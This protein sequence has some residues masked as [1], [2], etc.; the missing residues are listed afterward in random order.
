M[1]DQDRDGVAA[2]IIYPT[3]GMMLCNHTDVDYKRACFE[4]Y[5]RWI[6]EYCSAHPDRLLGSGPDRDAHA[7]GGHR[8]PRTTI[9]ALGLRGVMMPGRARRRGLRLDRS[10]TTFWEAAIE[11]GLPLSFHIL[12]SGAE[13]D[14]R[15][16]DGRLPVASSAAARTSWRCSCSA[17]CSSATRTCA[18]VCVEADAGWVPHFMY[19]MDHAYKRH[20]YWLPPGQELSKLP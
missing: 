2:E 10:T 7:R 6:A 4:A 18:I 20:R 17:A 14:A 15:P 1:A 3:V 11:L 8:R 19:R 16:E 12:T 13:Q 5:N 9:K